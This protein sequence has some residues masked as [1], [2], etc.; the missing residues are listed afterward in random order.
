MRK[1]IYI[2]LGVLL[3]GCSLTIAYTNKSSDTTIGK[4]SGNEEDLK[5]D[6]LKVKVEKGF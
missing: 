1:L 2:L 6:T 4:E 5:V 3:I